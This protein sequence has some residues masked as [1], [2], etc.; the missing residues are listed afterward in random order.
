MSRDPEQARET[1]P[2]GDDESPERPVR[3][4]RR[5]A[6]LLLLPVGAGLLLFDGGWIDQHRLQWSLDSLA[7]AES[8]LDHEILRLKELNRALE[9]GE[10]FVVEAE[11]R[12]L[13]MARPGDEVWRVML[14][15]DTLR[16]EGDRP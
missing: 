10:P 16:T 4:F 12:R 9:A 6:W 13:G 3:A 2:S 8:G 15:E 11:A 14:E 1:R 7:S 5:F